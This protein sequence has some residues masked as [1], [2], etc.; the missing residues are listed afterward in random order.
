MIIL[1]SIPCLYIYNLCLFLDL[2]LRSI[3]DIIDDY[4]DCYN[5]GKSMS[6]ASPKLTDPRNASFF[7]CLMKS[8]ASSGVAHVPKRHKITATNAA[9][10]CCPARQCTKT[11][12][13]AI[14]TFDTVS[15]V[16]SV[17]ACCT[18]NTCCRGSS[19]SLTGTRT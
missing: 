13:P 8:T 11:L 10:R 9:E 1:L 5:V 7:L 4:N 15:N 14:S 17:E 2:F 12:R 3:L 16:V 6:S 18:N 19:T